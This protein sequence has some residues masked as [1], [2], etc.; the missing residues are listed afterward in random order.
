VSLKDAREALER[1]MLLSSLKRHSGKI[2]SAAT[3]LGISRPTFYELM[4]KLGIEK[5]E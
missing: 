2:T 5:P 3:E 1:Q 4:A